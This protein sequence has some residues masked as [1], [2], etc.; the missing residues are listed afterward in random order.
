PLRPLLRPGG[1]M[2]R[3]FVAGEELTKGA[4][5]NCQMCGQC[6][7]HSTGM[8]CP[9][10]CPKNLRNGPCGGVRTNGHCEVKPELRWVWVDNFERVRADALA[11][12][13]ASAHMLDVNAGIPLAD[14]PGI[15]AEAIRVVQSVV[16]V[17]LSIDSSIVAALAAGLAAY[18]G[19]PL[20]N[21]VTAEDERL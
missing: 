3:V 13:A 9:M 15:L 21:S 12:V 10:N 11:Q 18:Q 4:L 14:E 19:K 20:V 6:V 16:D 1:T 7:L 8:T 17:P 2:E 5:F